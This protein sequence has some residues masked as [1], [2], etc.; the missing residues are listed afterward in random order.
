MRTLYR[1]SPRRRR[2]QWGGAVALCALATGSTA[3]LLVVAN[4]GVDLVRITPLESGAAAPDRVDR[5]PEGGAGSVRPSRESA[6]GWSEPGPRR[7]RAT[8]PS[9]PASTSASAEPR[10]EPTGETSEPPPVEAGGGASEHEEFWSMDDTTPR[11]GESGAVMPEAEPASPG[12]GSVRPTDA[13]PDSA[14]TADP[15][16]GRRPAVGRVRVRPGPVPV[17]PSASPTPTPTPTPTPSGSGA[18]GR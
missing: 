18:P 13:A 2:A 4:A 6:F 10:I 1:P 8:G 5:L 9:A 11:P 16:D 15:A 12:E 7:P 14:G 3:A 17:T